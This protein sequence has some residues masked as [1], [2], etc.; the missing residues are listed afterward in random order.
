MAGALRIPTLGTQSLWLDESYTLH[1]VR[2]SFSSMLATVPKTESTPPVYY[3]LAWIWSRLFGDSAFALRLLPALAGLATVAVIY[4][5]A[6]RVSG[7]RAAVYAGL[8]AA[9]APILVWFSQEARSYSL[10]TLLACASLLALVR[11]LQDGRASALAGWTALSA[12]GI[13]THYFV[14][15]IVVPAAVWLLA[16]RRADR[17]VLS[18][19]IAVAAV[20]LALIPLAATQLHAGHADW[21]TGI[22]LATRIAQVPKQYLLGYASPNQTLTGVLAA[23]L[24]AGASLPGIRALHRSGVLPLL[25]AGLVCTLAPILLALVGI[26]LLDT[27][28]L[29]PAVPPLLVV[30]SVLSAAGSSRLASACC[31]GGLCAVFMYVGLAIDATPRYQRNDWRGVS[32]ALGPRTKRVI[33]ASPDSALLPMQAYQRGITTL[34]GPLSTDTLDVIEIPPQQTGQGTAAPDHPSAAFRPPPGF[35]LVGARYTS[36]YA[37]LALRSPRPVILTP[38]T[39]SAVRLGAQSYTVLAQSR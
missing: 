5:L 28:N 30:A 8:L 23:L 22:D 14:A 7:R 21:L 38:A 1:L 13:A 9:C 17:R 20:G 36:T 34:T 12:L 16:R 18:G 31:V 3:V 2:L 33:V 4:V 26:D 35:K 32:S 39:L 27:R 15:F 29:L 24:L 25:S 19:V 10:A 37:V 6:L 11:F